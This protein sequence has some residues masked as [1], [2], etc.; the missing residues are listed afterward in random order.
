VFVSAVRN[1]TSLVNLFSREPLDVAIVTLYNVIEPTKSFLLTYD[2]ASSYF[3]FNALA[4]HT[5]PVRAVF[6][7][8]LVNVI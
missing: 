6:P 2:F 8:A 3:I 1:S 5:T 4:S 7:N